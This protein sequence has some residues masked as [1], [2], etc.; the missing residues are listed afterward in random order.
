MVPQM[1]SPVVSGLQ[2]GLSVRGLLGEKG[3]GFA[4]SSGFYNSVRLGTNHRTMRMSRMLEAAQV[5]KPR[6]QQEMLEKGI[7]FR[8][9]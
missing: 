3:S 8:K 5:F 7:K 6:Q 1:K 2:K 4:N 9:Q